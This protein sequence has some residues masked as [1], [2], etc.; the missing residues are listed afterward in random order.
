VIKKIGQLRGMNLTGWETFLLAWYSGHDGF[1][2]DTM[3]EIISSHR[4]TWSRAVP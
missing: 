2:H 3:D 1:G 4:R